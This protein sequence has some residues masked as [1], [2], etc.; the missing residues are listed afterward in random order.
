MR[1][2]VEK[3][4][5]RATVSEERLSSRPATKTPERGSEREGRDGAGVAVLEVMGS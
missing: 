4:L 2:E 3:W 5:E 1:S